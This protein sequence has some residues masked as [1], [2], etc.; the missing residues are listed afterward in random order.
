MRWLNN[1]WRT[2]NKKTR[3]ITIGAVAT[4]AFISGIVFWVG[5][6][7]GLE[8]ASTEEFCIS[9]HSM[10]ENNFKELKQTVHYSNHSG[11]TATC[12]DCHVPHDFTGKI[13]RKVAAVTDIWGS[14]TGSVDTP[15]KFEA[16]R[17][18]MAEGEWK[19]FSETKSATCKACHQYKSMKWD[20]MSMLAQKQM[21]P[22]AKIDQSC[23]DCHKGIAHKLPD[24]G[25]VRAPALIA[26]VGN[27][28]TDLTV[29]KTYYSILT[30]P[31]FFNEKTDVEAGMLN[32]A[33][34]VK[35]LKIDGNRVQISIDGW[36]KRIGLSRVIYLD[37]GVNVLSAQLS[38]SAVAEPG[39]IKEF[40]TKED[41]LTGINW[42]HVDVTIWTNNDYLL[43]DVKPLWSYG[44]SS[45][46]TSCS[47]CHKHPDV[48]RFDAN[49]WPSMFDAMKGF[50]N[51]DK[52]TKALVLKYLQQHSSTFPAAAQ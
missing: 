50:T 29:G 25:H 9:C 33:T 41:P 46:S 30:K 48:E 8:K 6:D 45:F 12:A 34:Q 40:E 17:L 11:V 28:V 27:G 31:L 13:A 23:V 2:L 44:R 38:K 10:E 18:K 36:R 51:M 20:E 16:K 47:V 37:F 32:V 52:E 39:T 35:I 21:Q 7:F 14:L 3:F 24:M 22:A 19:R 49:T 1:I 42:Q 4:L 5:L 15:E 43:G 26:Q